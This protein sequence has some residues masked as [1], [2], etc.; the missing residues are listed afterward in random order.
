M[1]NGPEVWTMLP[2]S[3]VSALYRLNQNKKKAKSVLKKWQI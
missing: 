2:L 3:I 1:M